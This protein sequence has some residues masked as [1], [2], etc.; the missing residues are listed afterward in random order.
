MSNVSAVKGMT[1]MVSVTRSF[2]ALEHVI[3]TFKAIEQRAATS[4]MSKRQ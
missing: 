2:D 4:L 3:D 1:D